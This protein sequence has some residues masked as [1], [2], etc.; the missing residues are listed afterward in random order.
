MP[1]IARARMSE[2]RRAAL[3]AL[4]LS[5]CFFK[6]DYTGGHFKC[7]D[8]QCPSG[9]SCIADSCELPPDAA[10]MPDTP[11]VDVHIAALTC[12]DPGLFGPTGGN[13]AGSTG[14]TGAADNV[15]ASCGGFVMNGDDDVYRVDASLG[16]HIMVDVSGS[17][18]FMA[19]AYV[20]TPCTKPPSQ[21]ACIGNVPA[22]AGNPI[23]VIAPAT[24]QYFIV[25]DN[26][27]PTSTGNYSLTVTH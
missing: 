17:G 9:L 24:T 15:S 11:M 23:N 27:N 16:D 20:V 14:G 8:G 21:P 26:P 2:C 22:S 12:A 7:S 18:G 19:Y 6:A 4:A 1:R 3:A 25:V 13:S 5:G 10:R